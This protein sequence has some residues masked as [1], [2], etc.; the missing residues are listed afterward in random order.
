VTSTFNPRAVV[1]GGS[2]GAIEALS[3]ILTTL[4]V[5]YPLAVLIV[6]HLPPD[7]KSALAELF[8]VKCRVEV[9]EA[10]DKELIRPGV[11][12]FAPPNYHLLVETD[13]AVSLSCDD[14][15]LYSRPSIDV[16]FESAADAYGAE[17]IGIILTGANSDGAKGLRRVSEAGGMAIAQN[18]NTAEVGTMPAAAIEAC[19]KARS[20]ALSEIAN[21]LIQVPN[22]TPSHAG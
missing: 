3:V 4:P 2:A 5:G 11:V 14:P 15:V 13:G 9:K 10:E 19:P 16:L 17:L 12:Y 8:S 1:I 18:P 21:L 7:T 20:L 22:P 6:V